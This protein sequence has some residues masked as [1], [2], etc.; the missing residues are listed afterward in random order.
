VRQAEEVAHLWDQRA[1][2][3][4][5]SIAHFFGAG[6]RRLVRTAFPHRMREPFHYW[7]RAHL[8]DVRL[9]AFARTGAIAWVNDAGRVADN[10]RQRN[11]GLYNDYFDDM[12]WYALALD[13]LHAASG[14]ERYGAQ[15]RVLREHC[16]RHGWNDSFGRSMA[17]RTAQLQYKNTPANGP[18]AILSARLGQRGDDRALDDAHQAFDWLTTRMRGADGIVADGINR[19]SDGAAD[20]W[21]FTYNQGLYIGAAVALTE[22]TGDR[23]PLTQ[24]EQTALATIAQLTVDGV[25][26]GESDGGDAGLFRGIF[27]RYLGTL[28]PHLERNAPGARELTA[29]VRGSTDRLWQNSIRD[30]FLLAGDDWR[31]APSGRV[32][33]S[34]QL[35]AVMAV[36]V[37]AALEARERNAA[38]PSP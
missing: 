32:A 6:E 21:R 36:E 30:G 26:A 29:F 11:H 7:W 4:Q 10:I 12:L 35:S 8:V 25:F 20:N 16:R 17:W 3:A 23:E 33:L 22:A 19:L 27:F 2:V 1:D 5:L 38:I 9:D 15:A 14:D 28:L 13:R 34:T 18:F 31:A 24:A 37:R